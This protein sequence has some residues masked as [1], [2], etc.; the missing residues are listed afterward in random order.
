MITCPFADLHGGE[1][2]DRNQWWLPAPPCSRKASPGRP[3]IEVVDRCSLAR[4]SSSL[5]IERSN[6]LEDAVINP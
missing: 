5:R 6:Y 1:W 3:E 2:V 4:C